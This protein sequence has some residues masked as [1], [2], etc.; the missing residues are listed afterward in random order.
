MNDSLISVI[1]PV[2]KV[3]Q[4]I[5]QCIKSLINQT[6]KNIEI[7]LVDDGSPDNCGYICED[8][9][10]KD[11]RIKVI[12]KKNGGLSDAR[13]AGIQIANGEYIGFVDSDDYLDSSFFEYLMNLISKNNA[14]IAECYSVSFLDGNVP[15][16]KYYSEMKI[17]NAKQWITETNL[18]DFISC[19]E[20]NKLYKRELFNNVEYPVGRH[21]EDEATTYKVIYKSKLIVRGRSELYFYRQRNDSIT[22]QD[23]NITEIKQRFLSLYEKCVYFKEIN[24]KDLEIFSYSKLLIYLISTYSVWEKTEFENKD[25]WLSIIKNNKH[26]V[27]KSKIVPF[28]YKVY[29][30]VKSVMIYVDRKKTVQ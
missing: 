24:E 15:K 4:Y 23:K 10:K 22:G 6:Y 5:D 13:N 12:H 25:N 26:M 3:E 14:D 20:W 16:P 29:I 1:V 17:L 18:G 11:N 2:Y 30:G 9:A 7:I 19:V 28:K 21:F 8:Y 27:Y